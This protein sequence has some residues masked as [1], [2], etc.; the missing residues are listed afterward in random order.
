MSQ[1]DL[2]KIKVAMLELG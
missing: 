2:L 1:D